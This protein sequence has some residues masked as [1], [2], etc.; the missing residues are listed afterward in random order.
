M[1]VPTPT[2]T[3]SRWH[4]PCKFKDIREGDQGKVF[5]YLCT[6][7]SLF[8]FVYSSEHQEFLTMWSVLVFQGLLTITVSS[9]LKICN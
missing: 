6:L 2:P 3:P 8:L 9:G 5:I 1:A 4:L 7:G